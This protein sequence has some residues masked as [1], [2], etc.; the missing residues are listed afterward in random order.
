MNLKDPIGQRVKLW[1]QEATIIG[2]VKDFHFESL[3]DPVKPFMFRFSKSGENVMIKVQ[4]GKEREAI[5]QIQQVYAAFNPGIPLHY[6]FLSDQYAALYATEQRIGNLA[7][8]FAGVAILISTLGLFGLVSFAAERRCKEIGVRK[9]LGA[10]EIGIVVLLSRDFLK[11]TILASI[12]S[13]PFG[14]IGAD[15]WLD[16]FAFR[17]VLHWWYFAC[18]CAAMFLI[19]WVTVGTKALKAARSNPTSSLR[20]E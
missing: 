19:A 18:P 5:S 1:G 8:Y 10:S 14:Y 16:T 3:Y 17:I 15:Q 9:I 11:L 7:L 12:I 6:R 4:P 2:V 13:L 20:S